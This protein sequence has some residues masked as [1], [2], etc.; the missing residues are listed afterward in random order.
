MNWIDV[1]SALPAWASGIF[2]VL[3]VGAIFGMLAI[4]R[5]MNGRLE[6][7]EK[8][9]DD[10]P[11]T[12]GDEFADKGETD[13]S[14]DHIKDELEHVRKKVDDLE[15]PIHYMAFRSG[16]KPDQGGQ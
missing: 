4:K 13:L 8:R 14:F 12:C 1:L 7:I 10:R 6:K 11:A 5:T 3:S 2:T 16:W 9:C 15:K